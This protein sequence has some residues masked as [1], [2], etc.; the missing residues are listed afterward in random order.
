VG[1]ENHTAA[2]ATGL[3]LECSLRRRQ[4]HRLKTFHGGWRD[5]QLADGT[6]IWTSP[7][8]RIYRTFPAGADLF[9]Q[10]RGPACA[11]PSP[12]RNDRSKQRRARITQA[13]KHNRLMQARQDEIAARKFRNH[14]RDMLFV[15][16]G[17]P[18]TSPYCKWGNDHRE[19]TELPAEWVPDQPAVTP[20]P[21]EPPF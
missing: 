8:G 17:T 15:F 18:S 10:P 4:H 19:P 2:C 11:A 7:T 14:M 20:L 9:P 12:I 13:R 5:T 1:Q 16:K 21:D 3:K 6:I